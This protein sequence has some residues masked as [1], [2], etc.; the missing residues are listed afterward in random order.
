MTTERIL[1]EIKEER[2]RQINKEG[3]TTEHDDEHNDCQLTMAAC[4]YAASSADINT[5]GSIDD[6]GVYDVWPWDS[7]WDKRS[8]HDRIKKLVIAGALIV[9]EIERLQRIV[10]RYGEKAIK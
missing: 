5:L 9:A 10:E 1:N 4:C 7:K 6:D 8:K 3:W 2:L